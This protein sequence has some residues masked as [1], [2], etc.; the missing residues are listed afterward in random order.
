MMR[1][2]KAFETPFCRNV[3][4]SSFLPSSFD[5][6][7]ASWRPPD[8]PW[9]APRSGRVRSRQKPEEDNHCLGLEILLALE[10]DGL[11]DRRE[12][13]AFV[14]QTI[15]DV[16]DLTEASTQARRLSGPRRRSCPRLANTL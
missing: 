6:P 13:H 9:S 2:I 5:L 4:I 8:P 10:S 14:D 7:R 15:N 11:L 3:Q 1:A 16:Q 12:A